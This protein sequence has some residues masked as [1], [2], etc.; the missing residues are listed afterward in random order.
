MPPAYA[1]DRQ[2]DWE[3]PVHNPHCAQ[4]YQNKPHLDYE[5]DADFWR[6]L[7]DNSDEMDYK[8]RHNGMVKTTIHWGQRKLLMSEIEFLTVIGKAGLQDATIV[9]A[10]AAPGTH[11]RYLGS[12]FPSVKFILVDPSPFS[13]Q[14][15]NQIRIIQDLF[16]D[17]LAKDLGCKG[18][19]IYFISDIRSTDPFRDEAQVVEERVAAD[20]KAQQTWHFLLNSQRSMLKFRLPWDDNQTLYLNGDIYLPVWGPQSTTECRLITSKPKIHNLYELYDNRRYEKQLFYFNNVTRHSL[21]RHDV[22]SESAKREGLD[23]CYDCRAEIEILRRYITEISPKPFSS[24][25]LNEEIAKLSQEISR[26]LGRN[27]T[28]ASPNPDPEGRRDRIRDRQWRDG[29]PAYEHA[30]SRQDTQC[31]ECACK[32]LRV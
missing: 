7:R 30:K 22:T 20:M 17:E 18:D 16:T 24:L 28:L 23:H 12:L 13:I 11:I 19:K 27:R 32:K 15:S 1:W 2:E 14:E 10:G 4:I 21:Y 6:I 31:L 5:T 9:Y 3:Q 26:S 25:T 29:K 8:P